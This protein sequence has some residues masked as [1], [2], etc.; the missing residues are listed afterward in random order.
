MAEKKA[1]VLRI[2]PDV[3]KELET[4][5]QQD[6]RSLNGQIEYLLSEALKKQKKARLK[7]G[8]GEG[9]KQI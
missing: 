1:F 7:S 3:L 6:F 5:A 2:N 9:K 8:D 4:W